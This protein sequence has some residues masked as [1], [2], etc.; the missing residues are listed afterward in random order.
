M[1]RCMKRG[2]HKR[3]KKKKSAWTLPTVLS[4]ILT[5]VGLVALVELK[6]RIQVTPQPALK[7]SEAC[8]APFLITNTGYL[9]FTAERTFCYIHH[10]EVPGIGTISEGAVVPQGG[11]P[12]E[13]QWGAT[14]EPGGMKRL[15]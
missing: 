14:S 7:G 13:G 15:M 9:S 1:Q 11:Y 8:S 6:A 5:A 3:P 10:L 4:L 2:K 12:A